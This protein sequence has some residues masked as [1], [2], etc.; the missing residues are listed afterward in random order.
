[1][2]DLFWGKTGKQ[3]GANWGTVPI[4]AAIHC[5]LSGTRIRSVERG[6]YPML[7][8]SNETD[9]TDNSVK[10]WGHLSSEIA[11][12]LGQL[13]DKTKTPGG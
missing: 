8:S 13:V 11:K 10:Q 5:T 7:C 12:F 9:K 6:I 1:M 3:L 2:H 4:W